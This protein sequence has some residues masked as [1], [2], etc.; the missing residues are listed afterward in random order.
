MALVEDMLTGNVAKVVAIGA[1]AAVLPR[2]IPVLP[3][4]LRTVL[5]SGL[6]LF[7]ESEADAEGGIIDK[8][9]DTAM[10]DVLA[11][12]S[13]PGT[14]EER[15]QAARAAVQRFQDT[16]RHRAGR[17]GRDEADTWTRYHRHMT[18]LK[19]ALANAEQGRP[20]GD[21]DA[22]RR[23]AGQIEAA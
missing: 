21:Q 12:L 22:L 14:D 15:H 1:V 10:K 13:G 6:K 19:R 20:H 3:A 5:K 11:S 23:V 17:Y 9:A 4:P 18:G 16:A 8:L 7:V 2:A